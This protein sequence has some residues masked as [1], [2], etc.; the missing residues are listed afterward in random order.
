MSATAAESEW[1]AMTRWER[2]QIYALVRDGD[3]IL[4]SKSET[5]RLRDIGVYDGVV[6]HMC[7]ITLTD[8]AEE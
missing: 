1:A 3:R 4:T 2:R 5:D 8:N 6:F 7:P